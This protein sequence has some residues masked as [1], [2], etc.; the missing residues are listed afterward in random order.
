MRIKYRV[1][2]RLVDRLDRL[3]GV[4]LRLVIFP[5]VLIAAYALFDFCQ[6]E[7]D[8]E[9]SGK[10]AAEF[11]EENGANEEAEV[12]FVALKQKNPEIVAWL[13]I[14]DTKIDFPVMHAR[15]NRFYLSHDYEKQF[16]ITGGIFLDYRN[17][18]D[19][20]DD[21]SIIYGHR[22]SSGRM[23]SDVGKFKDKEFFDRH[24][25]AFLYTPERN[26]ALNIVTFA[27]VEG[28]DGPIYGFNYYTKEES[29]ERIN[30]NAIN[31]RGEFVV[32]AKKY[33]LL[34]TCSIESEG[35]RDVLLGVLEE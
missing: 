12:D 11:V 7:L 8:A 22:M 35:E 27:S 4:L 20:L 23:F 3:S 10:L 33:V 26:Y 28:D 1:F 31:R 5:V 17:S 32:G 9:R 25:R 14:P 29:L 15:D 21:F 24:P 18:A 16:A 30:A 19:F 6:T 34:S 13:R 2:Y